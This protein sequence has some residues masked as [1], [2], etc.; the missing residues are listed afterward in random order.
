MK[1]PLTTLQSSRRHTAGFTVVELLV[2]ITIIAILAAITVVA[3]NGVQKRAIETTLKSDLRNAA[4]Q[5]ELHHTKKGTYPAQ[6][7]SGPTAIQA[8]ENNTFAYSPKTKDFC[9]IGRASCRE[10]VSRLV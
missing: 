8:S 1:H 4:S 2:V 10:R 7:M 6:I 3:Y 9:Q 5:L